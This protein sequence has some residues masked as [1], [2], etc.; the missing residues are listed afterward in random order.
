MTYNFFRKKK[1]E[2]KFLEIFFAIFYKTVKVDTVGKMLKRK[3]Q[4]IF[5]DKTVTRQY[6][7][8]Y[9]HTQGLIQSM[10]I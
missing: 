4:T 8:L 5:K 9:P 3:M 10:K 2:D 1:K 6:S 7:H